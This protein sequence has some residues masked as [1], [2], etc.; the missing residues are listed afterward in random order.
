M[1]LRLKDIVIWLALLAIFPLGVSIFVA[2]AGPA[3]PPS[4]WPAPSSTRWRRG[5]SG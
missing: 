1:T 4:E 2:L 3:E 5:A